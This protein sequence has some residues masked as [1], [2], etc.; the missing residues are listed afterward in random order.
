MCGTARHRSWVAASRGTRAGDCEEAKTLLHPS[1][2]VVGDLSLALLF[3]AVHYSHRAF[4]RR[5]LLPD[6]HVSLTTS[7]ERSCT[8]VPL[9][10]PWLQDFGAPFSN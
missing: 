10:F 9:S 2:V 4:R 1:A 5:E 3:A 6:A 7:F 8:K